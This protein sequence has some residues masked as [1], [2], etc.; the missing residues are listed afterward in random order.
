MS[1]QDRWIWP[2]ELLDKLG[3]GGMGVVYRARYVV[4][5][6]EF[7]VKLLP[8]DVTDETVLARFERELE[9]LKTLK[10]PHIVRTFGGVC[11]NKRRFYAME[12]VRG[13]TLEDLF[14][15]RGRLPWEQV[16]EYGQQMCEGLAYSHERQI[17]HR[18]I[19]PANFLLSNSG[20]L[21]LADF[22]L[23]SVAASRRITSAGMTAG[24][25][26]YMAPEQIR[27]EDV[28]PQTDIYA[29]GCVFYELLSGQ[30]PFDGETP[31]EILQKHLQKTP[32]RLGQLVPDCPPVLE[33]LIEE[34]MSKDAAERPADAKAVAARL[35]E[36][37]PEITVTTKRR[38]GGNQL[39]VGRE[40]AEI[41]E[42]PA[43]STVAESSGLPDATVT[44]FVFV[45]CALLLWVFSLSD[46]PVAQVKAEQLWIAAIKS[47]KVEV[48]VAAASALGELAAR[49]E[50]SSTVLAETITADDFNAQSND[51]REAVVVAA[52]K[53]GWR[54]RDQSAVLR[55][56]G[57][58][59]ENEQVRIA[60]LAAE[61]QVLEASEPGRSIWSMLRVLTV[62]GAIAFLG[63]RRWR[64]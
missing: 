8:K 15:K 57:K 53:A 14:I 54:L 62:I 12:L 37:T 21:K 9:I 22:G 63:W 10:H 16:V 1:D 26:H 51:F 27:G 50:D 56:I 59:D 3:E 60:A 44:A 41:P 35:K 34:M 13:G 32:Q 28:T 30:A 18:D 52:G 45:V 61:R 5:D 20:R 19:K 64:K 29:L 17:I 58:G 43:A 36:T 40:P 47:E 49:S 46:R 23:A 39:T 2:F 11:K 31:A 7:A 25:Y 33:S 24:T 38:P 42:R 55:K 6:K 4:N 48:R